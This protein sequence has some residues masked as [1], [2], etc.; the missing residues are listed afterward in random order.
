MSL[1]SQAPLQ[2]GPEASANAM[3]LW[4]FIE[5][6]AGGRGPAVLLGVQVGLCRGGSRLLGGGGCQMV[7]FETEAWG[8]ELEEIPMC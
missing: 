4:C 1:V 7:S 8:R 3:K 6:L 5:Q 2:R